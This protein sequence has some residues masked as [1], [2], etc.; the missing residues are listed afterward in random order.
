MIFEEFLAELKVDFSRYFET[1]LIDDLS[2]LR[3]VN[4]ALKKF[5]GDITILQDAVLEVEGG[6]AKLPD[7]FFSLKVAKKCDKDYIGVTSENEGILKQSLFWTDVRLKQ[8]DWRVCSDC[9]TSDEVEETTITQT[10][11]V[12][13]TP[14]IKHYKSPTILRL[15]KAFKRNVSGFNCENTCFEKSPYEINIRGNMLYTNFSEGDVYIKY[16]GVELDDDG[17]PIIPETTKGELLTYVLYFVK[18]NIL[19]TIM[20]NGDDVNVANL[21]QYYSNQEV[22]QLGLAMTDVKFSQLNP[23]TMYSLL[24]RPDAERRRFEKLYR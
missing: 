19:E 16:Y 13:K 14:F 18:R 21:F 5:G 2:V 6:K 4:Q 17:L 10:F 15:S 3:W 24:K 20:T 22:M 7:N 12:D 23:K 8:K 9:V 1:D 11:Y